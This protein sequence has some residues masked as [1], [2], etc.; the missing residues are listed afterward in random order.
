MSKNFAKNLEDASEEELLVWINT[1][2]PNYTKLASDELTRRTLKS[3]DKATK[4][5][6]RQAQESSRKMETFTMALFIIG[7]VQILVGL[8]QMVLS[9]AYS[10]NLQFKIFGVF[11][12]VAPLVLLA[13]AFHKIFPE[14]NLTKL[15]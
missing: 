15:P 5:N 12:S 6:A 8:L 3:L 13:F 7:M 11:V 4:E 9:F 14:N 2:D 1:L 10:N